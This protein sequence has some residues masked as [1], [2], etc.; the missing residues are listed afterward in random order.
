MFRYLSSNKALS[1]R[2]TTSRPRL[3]STADK[4]VDHVRG[5]SPVPLDPCSQRSNVSRQYSFTSWDSV[6]LK[7]FRMATSIPKWTPI[8][9]H[10][11]AIA[12]TTFFRRSTAVGLLLR[13]SPLS[14]STECEGVGVTVWE[15]RRGPVSSHTQYTHYIYCYSGTSLYRTP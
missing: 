4:T 10:S 1:M 3:S 9:S 13:S 15:G 6:A 7:V 2:S 8:S 5:D 12:G 11:W 14:A